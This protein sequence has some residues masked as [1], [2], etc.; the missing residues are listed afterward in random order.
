MISK[1]KNSLAYR[2]PNLYRQLLKFKIIAPPVK[3]KSGLVV[4]MMTG[5]KLISMTRLSI[6]SIA[7][8]WAVLPNLIIATDG[9]LSS[10][11]I[12][13]TLNFW[14]GEL[15]V[16]DWLETERYHS[17]K[18]R[19]NLVNYAHVNVLG[20]KL[21]FILHYAERYPVLWIDSD[22]LFYNDFTKFIP[23]N[24]EAFFCGGSEEPPTLH[25]DRVL[26]FYNN[27]PYEKYSF[28]S[29]IMMIKGRDIYEKYDIETLFD[30]LSDYDHYF[31]EQTIF[32]HISSQSLGVV[33]GMDIIKNFTHDNLVLQPMPVKNVIARHYTK[34]VR[35]LFWRDAFFN[36]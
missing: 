18:K 31:T 21:A 2:L 3:E 28:S 13:S 9:T 19:S 8:T 35:H 26:R 16:T 22:I 1:I 30:T 5:K 11:Q 27:N 23:S 6:F 14:P 4:I 15:E 12:K 29:G 7:K 17:D 24:I 36:L 34:N 33:W 25:D 10:E 32:A 20:K